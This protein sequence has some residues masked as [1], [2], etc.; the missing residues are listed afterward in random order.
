MKSELL[1]TTL[2]LVFLYF[3]QMLDLCCPLFILPVLRVPQRPIP[4]ILQLIYH[5]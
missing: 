3:V 4:S 1:S 2:V 5:P